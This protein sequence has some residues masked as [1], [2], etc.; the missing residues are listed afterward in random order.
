[1]RNIVKDMQAEVCC[2]VQPVDVPEREREGQQSWLPL[3]TSNTSTTR[4]RRKVRRGN[5]SRNIPT[6]QNKQTFTFS[7]ISIVVSLKKK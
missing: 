3:E 6:I 7:L 1:M 5:I 4:G 2:S